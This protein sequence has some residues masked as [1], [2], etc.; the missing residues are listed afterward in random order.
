VSGRPDGGAAAPDRRG[1]RLVETAHVAGRLRA[2]MSRM[3]KEGVGLDAARD[4]LLAFVSGAL[5]E[6][7]VPVGMF[8]ADL[9]ELARPLD[10]VV[11]DDRRHVPD[12]EDQPGGPDRGA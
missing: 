4:G 11:L 8:V 5:P 2:E 10:R 7:G 6:L 3:A 12:R 9:V 1:N